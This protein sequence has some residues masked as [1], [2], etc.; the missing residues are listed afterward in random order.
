MSADQQTHPDKMRP[1]LNQEDH[2]LPGNLLT[3]TEHVHIN[4]ETIVMNVDTRN[5]VRLIY[6]GDVTF[7]T[8]S[9]YRL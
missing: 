7:Y 5:W 1:D 4:N 9:I 8:G 3:L 2:L 6:S